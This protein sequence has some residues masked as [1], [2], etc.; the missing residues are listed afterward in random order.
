MPDNCLKAR[1]WMEDFVD[2]Q[3]AADPAAEMRAHLAGC[4]ACRDH[5]AEA[6]SLPA[7]LAGVP[8]PEPP[9]SLV[10]T[11]L[12]R[13]RRDQVSVTRLWAPFAVEIAL[14]AVAL[15][16][17][18]GLGGLYLLVQR[19]AAD[20]SA[21]F[22]WGAGQSDMPVPATGDVFLLLVCGLLIATTLY[23]LT[24]LSRPGARLS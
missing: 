11:V 20:A 2:G 1:E 9:A 8:T 5:H 4:P 6:V 22:S 12:N 10:R 16:Y 7:R 15:W 14:F 13:V 19:T 18:S 17:V 24:V 3:L 23:H 21:V